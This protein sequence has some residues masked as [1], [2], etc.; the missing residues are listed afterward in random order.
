MGSVHQLGDMYSTTNKI[1]AKDPSP[2]TPPTTVALPKE[3]ARSEEQPER[4]FLLGVGSRESVGGYFTGI[5]SA[6]LSRNLVRTIFKAAGADHFAD[7]ERFS[8]ISVIYGLKV[9]RLH[10]LLRVKDATRSA[11]PSSWSPGVDTS[12][13]KFHRI[14]TYPPPDSRLQYRVSCF[15]H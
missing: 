9:L 10:N 6:D 15:G 11:C 5:V 13:S 3:K 14:L 12:I 8:S 7:T 1:R 2:S 4:P